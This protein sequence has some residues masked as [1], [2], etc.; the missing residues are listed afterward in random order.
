[1]RRIFALFVALTSEKISLLIAAMQVCFRVPIF[2][3]IFKRGRLKV[4]WCQNDAKFCILTP[5]PVKIRGKVG[6][7]YL[8]INEA[9]PTCTTEPPEYMFGHPLRDC[10]ARCIDK[11]EKKK[12]SSSVYWGFPTYLSGELSYGR[13][14]AP[15]PSSPL[16][17]PFSF[18]SLSFPSP[19]CTPSAPSAPRYSR[20]RRST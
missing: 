4:K 17:S 9:L 13:D 6:E 2:C 1:M 19:P 12:S 16:T 8:S 7:I 15:L 3:C 5:P 11:R 20:L 14:S 10:W 18:L